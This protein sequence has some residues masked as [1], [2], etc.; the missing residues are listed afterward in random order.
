MQRISR[1]HTFQH[2]D[3][4]A[5]PIA[6]VDPGETFVVETVPSSQE[7]TGPIQVRGAEPG[8]ALAITVRDIS[9]GSDAAMWLKPGRGAFG[10]RLA[11][12]L[13]Q[14]V[15][16]PIP[17]RDGKAI[18]SDQ[19]AIPLRPM[20]GVAGV[21]PYGDAVPTYWPGRH[22]G[23]LD[24]RLVTSGNTLYLPVAAPGALLGIGDLH[25]AMG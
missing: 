11:D 19:I 7:A 4:T 18:F 2:F 21:A 20:I 5:S 1:L 8:D 17:L 16:R 13:R 22:G 6:Q 15:I 23:N 10:N 14:Q 25:A 9:F 24:C 12:S 3:R